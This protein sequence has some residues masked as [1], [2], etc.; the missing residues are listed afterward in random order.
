MEFVNFLEH[1]LIHLVYLPHF[2]IHAVSI[3]LRFLIIILFLPT[4]PNSPH[5]CYNLHSATRS[6]NIQRPNIL[7]QRTK[8]KKTSIIHGVHDYLSMCH[9]VMIMEKFTLL[10]STV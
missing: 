6:G 1:V 2:H 5:G 9:C 3:T 8:E 4:Y 10:F 7:W